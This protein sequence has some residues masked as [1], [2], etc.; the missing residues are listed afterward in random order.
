MKSNVVNMPTKPVAKKEDADFSSF[1]CG[2][3]VGA[4][5]CVI[6]NVV[7]TD[8]MYDVKIKRYEKACVNNGGIE[9]ISPDDEFVK[10]NNG[11]TFEYKAL[12]KPGSKLADPAEYDILTEQVKP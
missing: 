3:L 10:C 7:W 12:Y 6:I 8:K 5:I 9:F 11:A 4:V 1:V 2:L